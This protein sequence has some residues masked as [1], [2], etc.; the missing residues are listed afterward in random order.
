MRK[1]DDR[2]HWGGWGWEIT[3]AICLPSRRIVSMYVHPVHL[4]LVQQGA[5]VT[6]LLVGT[7]CFSVAASAFHRPP[8][9]M[10]EPKM[11]MKDAKHA[12]RVTC[13][14]C[15]YWGIDPTGLDQSQK[16]VTAALTP[17]NHSGN[18]SVTFGCME[19]SRLF[20]TS[21][22]NMD[23]ISAE[24]SRW[25]LSVT[26]AFHRI[27]DL[28]CRSV[29]VPMGWFEIRSPRP[30]LVW[31]MGRCSG[32]GILRTLFC[33]EYWGSLTKKP[34]LCPSTTRGSCK[35]CGGCITRFPLVIVDLRR[36]STT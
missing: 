13:Q 4:A 3:M 11:L 28:L 12:A 23:G 36:Y 15:T 9:N 26:M 5:A 30:A 35:Q 20:P 2:H 10:A 31:R 22:K 21:T 18:F 29:L 7:R 14:N 33:T 19:D 6:F 25:L 8:L 16:H 24:S 34:L 32:I 27:C 1:W 17:L